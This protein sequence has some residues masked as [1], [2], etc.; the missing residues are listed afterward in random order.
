MY[1][2]KLNIKGHGTQPLYI[3]YQS[4]NLI[5]YLLVSVSNC[6]SCQGLLR[7]I[8]IKNWTPLRSAWIIHSYLKIRYST[9]YLC[10]ISTFHSE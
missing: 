4:V 6:Q 10:K 1:V 2:Q 8:H 9:L 3:T 5:H 7:N